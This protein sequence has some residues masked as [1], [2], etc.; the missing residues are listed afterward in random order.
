MPFKLTRTPDDRIPKG[1]VSGAPWGLAAGKRR[2]RR[3]LLEPDIRVE[4][5]TLGAGQT[6]GMHIIFSWRVSSFFPLTITSTVPNK[7]VPHSFSLFQVTRSNTFLTLVACHCRPRGV[8]I[9]RAFRAVAIARSV[10]APD[11]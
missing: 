9:P 1:Y 11:F 10:V 8:V 6:I 7:Y 4:S 3:R 5:I 2:D